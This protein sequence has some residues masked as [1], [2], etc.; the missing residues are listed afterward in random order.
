[1]AE[2]VF[3]KF[4]FWGELSFKNVSLNG[5]S[6]TSLQKNPFETFIFKRLGLRVWL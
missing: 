6:M 4:S 5:F 2:G 1:M 3:S